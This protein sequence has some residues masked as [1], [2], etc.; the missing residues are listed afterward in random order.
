MYDLYKQNQ[1]PTFLEKVYVH[2]W[3]TSEVRRKSSKS[4]IPHK[5]RIESNGFV[6]VL[7]RNSFIGVHVHKFRFLVQ[8]QGL[9]K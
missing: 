5:L 8:N 1:K 3:R 9:G 7:N 2:L 6:K 4:K